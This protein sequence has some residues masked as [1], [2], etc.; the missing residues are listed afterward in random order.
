MHP[1]FHIV[2]ALSDSA[3][4]DVHLAIRAIP[5]DQRTEPDWREVTTVVEN[6]QIA[7][8]CDPPIASNN[9]PVSVRNGRAETGGAEPRIAEQSRAWRAAGGEREVMLGS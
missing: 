4:Q 6:C 8:K 3:L 7:F 2:P 1:F 5:A 9:D